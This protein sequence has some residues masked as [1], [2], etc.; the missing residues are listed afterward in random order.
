MPRFS[1]I[2]SFVLSELGFRKVSVRVV[3]LRWLEVGW[4]GGQF[5]SS[6]KIGKADQYHCFY[7]KLVSPFLL[8]FFQVLY[9]R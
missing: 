9:F 6:L 8:F 5:L 3:G 1:I 7:G 2:E 4:L